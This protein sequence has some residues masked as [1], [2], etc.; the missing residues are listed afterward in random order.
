MIVRNGSGVGRRAPPG[1]GSS[2]A[3]QASEGAVLKTVLIVALLIYGI[4]LW[5]LRYQWRS[6]VYRMAS[7]KIN[8]LPWFGK[9]LAA[10][11]SNRYFV[12][13]AERRMARRFRLYLAGYVAL[14]AWIVWLP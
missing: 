5:R 11:F 10:L 4:P 9:D 13:P 7:W 8:V 6:T 3:R 2:Q 14:L 12:T 1:R